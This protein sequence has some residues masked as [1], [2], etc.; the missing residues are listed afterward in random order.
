MNL[1]G[2]ISQLI[3]LFLM[4][5]FGYAIGRFGVID[6]NFR[7]K[8]SS[9]TLNTACP[10]VIISSVLQ[11]D[12]VSSDLLGA[13]GTAIGFFL[14]M[15]VLASIVVRV[16]RTPME[17][18]GLDQL[19]LI[20]T[21]I[22]FMGIPVVQSLYGADGVAQLSMF[23]L[24]FNLFFF[25]YG[26]MLIQ[27]GVKFNWRS[28]LNSC[29]IAALLALFFGLTNL[30]LPAPIEST[31][32]SIG[33]MNTPLA[34][35]IIGSSMAFSDVRAALLNKRLYRV[36]LL[37]MLVMPL[38]ILAIVYFLP[39]PP[40]LAGLCVILAAMPIAGNCGM[41][42]DIYLPGEMTGAQAVIVTTL[43]S[44]VTLPVISTLVTALL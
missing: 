24:I 27:H 38:L 22:G 41:L 16:V 23:I 20:F 36:G 14:V 29:I 26:V 39:L 33:S 19:M 10:C 15:I 31:L 8:L 13:I 42:C 3:S 44:G 35:M 28:L 4:M 18:R 6:E 11:S 25:S 2:V 9:F 7:K 30:R 32:A 37:S 40:M 12:S 43:M 34:M 5:L 17:E 21:N 1:S